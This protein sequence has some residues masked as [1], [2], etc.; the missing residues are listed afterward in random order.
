MFNILQLLLSMSGAVCDENMYD[1]MRLADLLG[2]DL[3]SATVTTTRGGTLAIDG[4][5]TRIDGA[6]VG[7]VGVVEPSKVLYLILISR[8]VP[9]VASQFE[10][11]ASDAKRVD[12]KYGAGFTVLASVNG[13]ACSITVSGEDGRITSLSCEAPAGTTAG[14]A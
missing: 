11:I 1:P 8:T 10:T 2:L 12:S 3:S 5:R 14:S 7:V 4:A 13:A 6:L 9:F